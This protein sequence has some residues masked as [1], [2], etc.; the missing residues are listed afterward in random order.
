MTSP[1]SAL[2]VV[3]DEMVVSLPELQY[4]VTYYKAETS[5]QLH[6]R[7]ITENTIRTFRG[8]RAGVDA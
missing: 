6:A 1:E 8:P 2:H 5:P 4:S 3:G 7:H